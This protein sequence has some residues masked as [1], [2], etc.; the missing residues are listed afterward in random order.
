MRGSSRREKNGGGIIVTMKQIVAEAL[1]LPPMKRARVATRL[2]R[3]LE[4][5]PKLSRKSV[6]KAW[7]EEAERRLKDWERGSVKA[8]PGDRVMRE[9]RDLLA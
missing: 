1:K 7:L 4:R 9:L 2:I 8:I 6:E 5:E 3:S